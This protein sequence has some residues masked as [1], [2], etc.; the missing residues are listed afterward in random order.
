MKFN[1]EDF[2]KYGYYWVE[3]GPA[4]PGYYRLEGN[5]PFPICTTYPPENPTTVI[6]NKDFT[7]VADELK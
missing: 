6:V 5:Y 2:H 3:D 7:N 4:G 1:L